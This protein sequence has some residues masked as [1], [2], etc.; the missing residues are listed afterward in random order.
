MDTME[1]AYLIAPLSKEPESLLRMDE[2]P[3]EDLSVSKANRHVLGQ[4]S[5]MVGQLR[6]PDTMIENQLQIGG[7]E[8]G[9]ISRFHEHLN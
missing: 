9:Q 3:S 8:P 5:L 2:P 4:C 6:G 7:V 1:P